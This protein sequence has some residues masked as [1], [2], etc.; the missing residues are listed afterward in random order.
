MISTYRLIG[1]LKMENDHLAEQT[2][3]AQKR[4]MI[5][6]YCAED[7][8]FEYTDKRTKET[9]VGRIVMMNLDTENAQIRFTAGE[10]ISEGVCEDKLIFLNY[11]PAD[12]NIYAAHSGNKSIL[13][14]A[15]LEYIQSN[16]KKIRWSNPDK[17]DSC[18]SYLQ[19]I[20]E[21]FFFDDSFGIRPKH[22]LLSQDQLEGFPDPEIEETLR[23]ISD[24]KAHKKARDKATKNYFEKQLAEITGE[25]QAYAITINGKF[26][27]EIDELAEC[28]LDVLFYH[29]IDKQF[30]DSKNR[31]HCHLCAAHSKLSE[32]VSLKHKFYGVKN[33][34]YFDG[35]S[36]GMNSSAFALCQ[37]CY[38]EVTVGAQYVSSKF[39]TYL[40][41]LNC[42]VLP[43][44]DVFMR[45]D[46]QS[47]AP[48][49]IQSI[50]RL[51]RRRD[52]TEYQTSLGIVK[53]LQTRLRG[54]SLFFYSKPSATS[55]EF[56]VSQLIKGISLASLIQKCENLD[57]MSLECGLPELF[58]S[59]YGLSFEGLRFL[60]LPSQESHPNLKP[61]EYQK[62][63]RDILSLLSIYLYSQSLSHDT[64]I[65][66][67]VDIHSRK[68]NNIGDHSTY[69]LDLS[70]YIMTLY[71]KHLIHF[72]QLRGLKSREERN[73][74]T[75]LEKASLL[76][77][78]TNNS[79]VYQNNYLAQGLFI[80]G[81]YISEIER[82]QRE[83][84]IRKTAISKLNLRG[85]PVQKVKSVMA[86]IDDLREVWDVYNDP[87]TDAY[88]RECMNNLVSSS[89]SPEETVFHIL[90]G[91]AYNSYV[92]I[93][94][95]IKQQ[96]NKDSQEAQND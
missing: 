3:T 48:D 65:K 5:S 70:A 58:N 83:K 35:A 74:T 22:T 8:S 87:I 78:F 12:P 32:K 93:M 46:G 59:N 13:A 2:A 79:E 29:I 69:A 61:L 54:F 43:D 95:Y 41:G 34:Y 55:Q 21:S 16:R 24:E 28:Y 47:L 37:D 17:V 14:F 85:I 25:R 31:G 45:N 96:A 68:R 84:G 7:S 82:K 62:I 64:I 53:Q 42:F 94:E 75:T 20:R 9:N 80:M 76:D 39:K 81:V 50:P 92:G 66:Q 89:F 49:G 11:A 86:V 30:A 57:H 38:N 40:F 19:S 44:F 56:I 33:P 88:Y 23:D 1:K 72:N 18:I 36:A 26:I 10:E 52:K 71:I 67:Y 90:S 73:M 60:L 63:N 6:Q 91:R 51:L 15:L 4:Y 77:Y 27:H